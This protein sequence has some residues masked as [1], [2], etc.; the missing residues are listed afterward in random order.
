[1][2]E[3]TLLGTGS[4]IPDADRA[5]PSTLVRAGDQTFLV[6]CGRGVQQRLTA[7]GTGAN[8]L[9]AL[10][11]THLHS[12]HI[13][14]L[15]DVIITRWVSTFTP[16]PAPLPIIGPPG[17][18]EVVEATLKA[19]GFDIGYRIA[20]HADLNSPPP[21]EVFEY[22]DGPVWDRDGV[23]IRVAPTDHRPVTPTIGFR[24][25]HA[26]ASVV[27]AGDSV[28]CESLDAL[29]SGAGALVHTVI[30]KDLID[31]MPMQRIR[32][33]CD[34]H[35]SVEEA[36]ATATRAGVGILILTHYVPAIAPGQEDEWRALAATAFDRQIEL[37]DD[38]HRVEV[39]PGVCAR[40]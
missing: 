38:L 29:A 8:A 3:V 1:M 40:S 20:H 2:I 25:E 12:D 5:G 27:L 18:A 22:T 24:V 30:R 21:V 9:T 26:G 19:F 14:D 10:L 28:P 15:G 39:H 36:A 37:G 7:A 16:D 4:P 35:S 23:Q 13:A 11:L 6:D 17:T 33:I 32:D 34:Y 31:P